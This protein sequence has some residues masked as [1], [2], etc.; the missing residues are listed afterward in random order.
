[1]VK[2][3]SFEIAALQDK[4]LDILKFFQGVCKK[5]HLTYWAGTGTCLGA[6]R[7]QGFIP[8]DDDMD[9]YMPRNDYENLWKIWKR[10][11][12]GSK[13]KL[14]RTS[15]RKNY[16]HRAMQIVDLTTTFINERC[17]N[18]DI[19]HGVYIDIIP[20]DACPSNPFLRA[21]QVFNTVLYSI[22]NI[23]IPPDFQGGKAMRY[24]TRFLLGLVKNPDL[25][26][27]IWRRAEKR[28]SANDIETAK[29]YTDL[30]IYFW[31]IFKPMPASWFKTKEVPFED[32]VINVPVGYDNYLKILY[33]DYMKL[34]P[35][36]D[37][38]VK[39]HTVKIDIDKPYTEYRGIYY[40]KNKNR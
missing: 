28:L 39:H 37:R 15:R 4:M 16:R 10:E 11:A 3:N 32:T 29:E 30:Y 36:E 24:G 20:M 26:Y 33:G 8:W 31:M 14:C 7:H 23:Q 34:P 12:S 27:K 21:S 13:Y 38:T 17:V 25:R 5:N 22:Y 1:M 9:I 18:D 35:V 2:D 19:E 6:I 40:L